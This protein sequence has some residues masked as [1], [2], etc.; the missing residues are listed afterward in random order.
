MRATAAGAASS[1]AR[2]GALTRFL[3]TKYVTETVVSS[4]VQGHWLG[5]LRLSV[6]TSPSVTL[7]S[8]C[9][10]AEFTLGAV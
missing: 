10:E 8:A 2:E 4:L 1:T 5:I 3:M 9:N 6:T 7:V